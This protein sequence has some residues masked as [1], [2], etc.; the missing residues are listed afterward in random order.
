[1]QCLCLFNDEK[2]SR[3][4]A[5]FIRWRHVDNRKHKYLTFRIVFT[6]KYSC[7]KPF[8]LEW[9]SSLLNRKDDYQ[10]ISIPELLDTKGCISCITGLR[11]ILDSPHS[12]SD[13]YHLTGKFF[14]SVMFFAFN[15]DLNLSMRTDSDCSCFCVLV[16]T[17]IIPI[18]LKVYLAIHFTCN[19]WM[20]ITGNLLITYGKSK[21]R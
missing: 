4:Y 7:M 1:M 9:F 8:Q 21:M 19:H 5:V 18:P 6:R 2:Q 12:S 20:L 16:P 15:K 14:S 13:S 3:I 10:R 17:A 11:V